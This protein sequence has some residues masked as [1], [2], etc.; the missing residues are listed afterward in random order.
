MILNCIVSKHW[1][2]G[3]PVCAVAN[4]TRLVVCS[5]SHIQAVAV[6]IKGRQGSRIVVA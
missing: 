3:Y 1:D 2:L 5:I 6:V 4:Q